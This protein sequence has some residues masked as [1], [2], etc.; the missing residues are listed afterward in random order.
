MQTDQLVGV[1]RSNEP[2]GVLRGKRVLNE[3]ISRDSKN[4]SRDFQ[5]DKTLFLIRNEVSFFIV[6]IGLPGQVF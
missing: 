5:L 2:I 4:Q 1:P 3:Y 6:T